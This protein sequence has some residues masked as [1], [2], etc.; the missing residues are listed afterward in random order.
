MTD[1]CAVTTPIAGWCRSPEHGSST[2]AELP[3]HPVQLEQWS[4]R[5]PTYLETVDI[6]ARAILFDN[7]GVLVDSH[8]AGAAA[9][10]QLCGEFGLDFSVVSAVFVGRRAEDT[11]AE[12]VEP[13]RLL[14]AI[15]RLED[16]EV[17]RASDTPLIP[18]ARGFLDQLG[19]CPWAVVTSASRRLADARWKAAGIVAP[20]T[21]TADEVATGKPSP[22]P[23]LVGAEI[24]GV[25]PGDCLVFE[26]S[27]AGFHAGVSAGARVVAVGDLAWPGEPLARISS[28]DELVNVRATGDGIS[29]SVQ[30]S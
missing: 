26:D 8:E 25:E 7:D 23:Y 27:V 12:F 2:G 24:L 29:F 13:A 16:L 22:E 28:F 14:D 11:L 17:E 3:N 6:R 10:E 9:W 30:P 1:R 4:S 20:A 5:G 15:E 19:T 18:G 21:V